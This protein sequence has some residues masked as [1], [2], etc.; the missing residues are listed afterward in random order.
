MSEEG[1]DG[2]SPVL[3]R[4]VCTCASDQAAEPEEVEKVASLASWPEFGVEL[5]ELSMPSARADTH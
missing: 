2:V 5:S 1:V 4:C 3:A